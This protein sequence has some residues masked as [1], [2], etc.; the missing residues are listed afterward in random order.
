MKLDP[1]QLQ[2]E[3]KQGQAW[4]LYWVHGEE[5]YRV[6]EVSQLLART[7]V[8]DR[9]W[10]E[11]RLE[12]AHTSAQ[13]VVASAQSIPLGGGTRVVW[14]RDAQMI[15]DPD[16]M[17]GLLG[18]RQALSEL[19]WCVILLAKDL[20]GRRKFSKLLVDKAAVVACESVPEDQR[21][22]WVRHMAQSRGI[23]PEALPLDLLLRNEPWSLDWVQNEISKWEMS[24]Q[25]QAGSGFEV[26]VGGNDGSLGTGDAFI[27][28]FLEKRSLAAAL[29]HAETLA[30]KPEAS[31]PLLG[32]LSWNVRML[33]L[34]ASRSRS[35]RIPPFIEGKLRRVL[36]SWD[37]QEIHDLQ[38]ALFDLD[39]AV[40]QTPQEPVALWGVL[41]HQF[42][43]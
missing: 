8:G 25:A 15:K 38:T 14:V 34:L 22:A 36:Q 41:I 31:L 13:D 10:C 23:R 11:D 19:P 43:R 42:C 21:E 29:V 18:P 4:P 24:E 16:K 2:Q 9:A 33:A 17:S 20:D 26:V 32:L 30:S 35:V 39:F 12:G 7:V 28:A 6:R 40:K 3:L 37:S 5:A 27:H 1:K